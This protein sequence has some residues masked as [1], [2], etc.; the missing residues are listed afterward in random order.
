MIVKSDT[1]GWQIYFH[2]AHALLAMKIAMALDN[3]LW[4]LPAYWADG[5]SSI[6]EHDDGQQ[7]WSGKDHL[8][9]AGAPLDYR[10]KKTIDLQQAEKAINDAKYKS[11]FMA[12]MISI[13][14]S[15][16]H[17]N[18]SNKNVNS[19][20]KTQ[21]KFRN[22]IINHLKLKKTEVNQC[23]EF[24]R[25]CDELSLI[26]CQDDVLT[27]SRSVEVG[28]LGKHGSVTI[29]KENG[30]LILDPWCFKTEDLEINIEKFITSRLEFNS[31]N[32]LKTD[33]NL[34]KP[35]TETF[36]FAKR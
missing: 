6:T 15:D 2:R 26:L 17:K 30:H 7:E 25:W 10:N 13:H 31:D 33:L 35:E 11:S 22:E 34:A 14:C 5:L 19:F 28:K 32:D 4:P 24:L 36:V 8:T 29:K 9:E 20:L 16:L 1:R 12:L 23:Y 27:N 3:T 18:F 21:N